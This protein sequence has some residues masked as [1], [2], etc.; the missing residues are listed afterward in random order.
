MH[1][2]SRAVRARKGLFKMHHH[3]TPAT[4]ILGAA[5]TDLSR[6]D[7]SIEEMAIHALEGALGDATVDRS[8]VRMVV[9]SN[10]LGGDLLSQACIRGE[11]WLRKS[12]LPSVPIINIENSCGSGASA[13]QVGVMAAASIGGP[14]L[15][16]GLEKM[17]T[18]SRV[19]TMA[20]IEE[21]L[22]H[23]YR[24]DLHEKMESTHNPAGSILMGL[25][26]EWAEACMERFGTTVE[27]MAAAAAKDHLHASW[28]PLAQMQS[29]LS[30]EE[31]L[32]A[33]KVVGVLTRPM[34]SSF[35]DGAA[36]MVLVA[37]EDAPKEV[38]RIVGS[39]GVSGNGQVEYH[40]RLAEAGRALYEATGLA[41]EEFDLAE[42]HDAT[43]A[44]EIFAVETLGLLPA[45]TAGPATLAGDTTIGGRSI[46][47]NPS[48]GL[49]GR[50]HPLGA[51]GIAQIFELYTHL[52]G[53]G[54]A[55]QV[56]GAEVA[57]AVNTGGMMFGDAAYI[58]LHALRAGR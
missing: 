57:L 27:Q 31:V 6:R 8:R 3:T 9:V 54:G 7:L 16:L 51:T 13:A 48:G 2:C 25:N 17:W 40:D 12:G 20:A 38:P 30:I 49:V 18:G 42:L 22:P 35:T 14:I 39:V 15:V 29:A 46:T 24:T 21:G 41:P 4:A 23:D 45:G 50:G 33:P 53:R 28:N 37:D 44:E 43:S 19:A 32:A 34:C 26:D 56:V 36:A 1:P 11:S 5:M 55:R 47:I 10:A 52:R 58:G